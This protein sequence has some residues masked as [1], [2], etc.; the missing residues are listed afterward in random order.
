MSIVRYTDKVTGRVKL[1]ESTSRYD[2]VTKQ[3]RPIRKYLGIADPVTGE[4]IPSSGKPGRKKLSDQDKPVSTPK[5]DGPDYKLL[6]EKQKRETASKNTVIRELERKN[7][8]LINNLE[9]MKKM[10]SEML[11][12]VY[13][14]VPDQK[15]NFSFLFIFYCHN[16]KIDA[17]RDFGSLLV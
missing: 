11:S 4:L 17:D 6:Y 10:T 2:P 8:L 5:K 9:R 13:S 3:S 14:S 12:L 7:N 16:D 1:Y 15:A